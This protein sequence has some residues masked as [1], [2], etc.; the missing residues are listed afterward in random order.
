VVYPEMCFT[1]PDA[2]AGRPF[3]LKTLEKDEA[4][5][6]DLKQTIV[7][8]WV[9]GDTAFVEGYFSGSKIGGTLVGQ[10]KGSEMKLNFLDRIDI[11]D[12]MI[13]AVHCYYDTA[14]LYQ[15]QLGVDG[16]TKEKP[17]PPWMVA[18]AAGKRPAA[19]A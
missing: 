9:V 17:V 5:F 7:N 14:L 1:N 8:L 19:Q 13:K 2:S 11:E 16:P 3:L 18:M 6:L 12:R 10:A 4:S 15:V